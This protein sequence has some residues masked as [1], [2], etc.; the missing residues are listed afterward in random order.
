MMAARMDHGVLVLAVLLAVASTPD[1]TG[2]N[3]DACEG[4]EEDPRPERA[5]DPSLK[6]AVAKICR[7]GTCQR[8]G[9]PGEVRV[10]RNKQDRVRLLEYRGYGCFHFSISY[11]DPK[12]KFL[13]AQATGPREPEEWDSPDDRKIRK[14]REGLTEAEYYDCSSRAP[15]YRDRE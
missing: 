14:L 4:T 5:P 10:W 2:A 15:R 9:F 13:V 1:V 7:K 6:G 11:Y 3:A 12:G 8:A